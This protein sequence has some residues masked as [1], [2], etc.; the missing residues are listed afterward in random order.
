MCTHWCCEVLSPRSAADDRIVKLPLYS[1]SGI[2]WNWLVDPAVRTVECFET[3][4]GKPTLAVTGRDSDSPV[5][6]PFDLAFPL[7]H[8]WLRQAR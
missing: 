2:S 3:V 7:E 1:M 5:L 8:W 6:P 4:G